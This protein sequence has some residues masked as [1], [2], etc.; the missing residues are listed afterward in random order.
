MSGKVG[1]AYVIAELVD[2]S[3]VSEAQVN[4][5]PVMTWFRDDGP[6]Q[7]WSMKRP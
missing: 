5:I 2:D 3:R 6:R 4:S 7:P 1:D